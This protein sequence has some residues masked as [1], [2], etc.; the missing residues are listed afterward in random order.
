M[1]FILMFFWLLGLLPEGYPKTAEKLMHPGTSSRKIHLTW[2]Q[3]VSI[4]ENLIYLRTIS[5]A[6]SFLLT[7]LP[8]PKLQVQSE[9]GGK[10]N[11]T[12]FGHREGFEAHSKAVQ[13]KGTIR[14]IAHCCWSKSDFRMPYCILMKTWSQVPDF[15]FSWWMG[16]SAAEEST[17]SF[18]LFSFQLLYWV[19]YLNH[20]PLFYD[21]GCIPAHLQVVY[22]VPQGQGP[23][24]MSFSREEKWNLSVMQTRQEGRKERLAIHKRIRRHQK[25]N[26]TDSV[27]SWGHLPAIQWSGL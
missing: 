9:R 5:L 10:S 11:F 20:L 2:W 19:L 14:K 13:R 26:L 15:F 4:R 23:G 24:R 8:Y 1:H 18:C 17:H 25:V 27:S 22:V 7:S 6:I 16:S 21:E 3:L 12:Q